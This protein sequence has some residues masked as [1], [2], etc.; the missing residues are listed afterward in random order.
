MSAS[1]TPGS[2]IHRRRQGEYVPRPPVW[3]IY[4][5]QK[6]YSTLAKELE[7]TDTDTESGIS[8]SDV[9][10]DRK[11]RYVSDQGFAGSHIAEQVK[12]MAIIFR[13]KAEIDDA[14]EHKEFLQDCT[15]LRSCVAPGYT[16]PG[17]SA[18]DTKEN[19]TVSYPLVLTPQDGHHHRQTENIG[20]LD[21]TTFGDKFRRSGSA[22]SY[23]G[24][25]TRKNV[26]TVPHEN[27]PKPHEE[28]IIALGASQKCAG[29]NTLGLV[30]P[31][32]RSLSAHNSIPQIPRVSFHST[33]NKIKSMKSNKSTTSP[34]DVHLPRETDKQIMSGYLVAYSGNTVYS[35]GQI[36]LQLEPVDKDEFMIAVVYQDGW[37]LCI[38]RD[39]GKKL[40]IIPN[41]APKNVKWRSEDATV[42]VEYHKVILR[43]LPVCSLT[44]IAEYKFYGEAQL[45][46]EERLHY[47]K[48]GKVQ[49]PLRLDSKTAQDEATEKNLVQI[50][51]KICKNFKNRCEKP[52]SSFKLPA[53]LSAF[54][55]TPAESSKNN[56]SGQDIPDGPSE[57]QIR[58]REQREKRLQDMYGWSPLY[59]RFVHLSPEQRAQAAAYNANS[60][61]AAGYGMRKP[62]PLEEYQARRKAVDEIQ[63]AR[64]QQRPEGAEE[65]RGSE[66]HRDRRAEENRSGA[67]DTSALLRVVS[68]RLRSPIANDGESASDI[69]TKEAE[70]QETGNETAVNSPNVPQ[71]LSGGSSA[72][73]TAVNSPHV[74]QFNED[75]HPD[76]STAKKGKGHPD[77]TKENRPLGVRSL[78]KSIGRRLRGMGS[79][80]NLRRKA[81]PGPVSTQTGPLVKEE[82]FPGATKAKGEVGVAAAG[83][84]LGVQV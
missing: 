52:R 21:E 65:R 72:N 9:F 45:I 2:F 14:V 47:S 44:A 70:K 82:G 26:L 75:I 73:P 30:G 63:K 28:E 5:T 79:R 43:F 49:P 7:D 81:S 58:R 46:Q 62:M 4:N 10:T 51:E 6:D 68:K 3:R 77:K 61:P 13:D 41:T 83:Q 33:Y 11:S 59:E 37:A 56:E 31:Q 66:V 64:L 48:G 35:D 60:K 12:K 57:T 42:E 36:A 84:G 17:L 29:S 15:G 24:L 69:P 32:K 40:T 8:D 50:Q 74:P 18:V 16:V 54:R 76:D 80:L 71:R 19:R 67:D 34:L 53:D 55:Q 1:S 25:S 78:G 20:H 38:K 22:G 23:V 39:S 27:S